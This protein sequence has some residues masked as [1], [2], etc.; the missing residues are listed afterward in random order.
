MDD[1]KHGRG[2]S[3]FHPINGCIKESL[4]VGEFKSGRRHG[5]GRLNF[6]NCSS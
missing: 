5:M 4:Y 6:V 2:V 1:E 3:I